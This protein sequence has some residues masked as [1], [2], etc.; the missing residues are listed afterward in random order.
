MSL[1]EIGPGIFSATSRRDSLNSVVVAAGE[2][3]PEVLLIDPGWEPDELDALAQSLAERGLVPV[4]GLSTHAHYD[5][6]LWHPRFGDVPRW[7][8]TATTRL[9]I[10]HGAELLLDLG[11]KYPAEVIG[12]FGLQRAIAG[13]T[14]PWSWRE[15]E[16]VVHDGHAAGHT[17]AWIPDCRVL[18]AG[19]MLSDLE[20]PLLDDTPDASRAVPPSARLSSPH[21]SS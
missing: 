1:R 15:I 3:E 18:I 10:E 5:H 17:A 9:A 14:L 4:A 8:S 21:S 16:L 11:P 2:S 13:S 12:S 6:L 7:A 20:I 19:D